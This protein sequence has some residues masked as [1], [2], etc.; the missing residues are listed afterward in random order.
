MNSARPPFGEG[1][2][3]AGG[4]TK[5][6]H[7]VVQTGASGHANLPLDFGIDYGAGVHPGQSGIDYQ[8]LFRAPGGGPAGFNLSNGPHAQHAP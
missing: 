1:R 4:A 8:F 7:P 3:C 5:R 2:R 6:I